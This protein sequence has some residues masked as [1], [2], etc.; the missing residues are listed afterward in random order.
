MEVE[1]TQ[2][3]NRVWE[4]IKKREYVEKRH[5]SIEDDGLVG[6]L[7]F[8]CNIM[9]YDNVF[10]FSK[11]G[12][13]ALD[14]VCSNFHSN[15][16]FVI[17]HSL[18]MCVFFFFARY[19]IIYSNCPTR[20]DVTFLSVSHSLLDLQ[21]MIY[22]L[23]WSKVAQITTNTYTV[24]FLLSTGQVCSYVFFPNLYFYWKL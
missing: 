21:H 16:R 19:L 14:L 3:A 22:W 15:F 7:S 11:L 13:E 20:I 5:S 23:S 12:L 10:K 4:S 1:L 24:K 18:L 6:M 2:L 9:K 17:Y 8:M